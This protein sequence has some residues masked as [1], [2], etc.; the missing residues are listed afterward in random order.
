MLLMWPM[1]ALGWTLNLYQR[2]RASWVRLMD[3]MSEETE[4]LGGGGMVPDGRGEVRFD[5]VTVDIGGRALV[6][7]VDLEIPAGQFIA[8]VGPTGAGKSTL[9]RLLARLIEPTRGEVRLDGESLAAWDLVALRRELAFVPQDGFLFA[10]SIGRNVEL[11]QPDANRSD[12]EEIARLVQLSGEIDSFSDGFET[13]V[14]ERGVTLSGGQRQRVTLARALVR[15]PR[16]LVLD[17][18]FSNMD[19]GTEEAILRKTREALGDRTVLLVSHRLTTMRRAERIV[20]L[21]EGRVVEDGTYAD[22]LERGGRFAEFVRRQ[23][24]LDELEATAGSDEEEA[25]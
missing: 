21:E 19:T 8:I 1:A 13:V 14:G 22:L 24:L 17:D 5:G 25:A 7:D 2:G 20:Y 18:A 9:A 10:E 4:P 3:L 6:R 16:V 12:L 15:R 11:G 23:R